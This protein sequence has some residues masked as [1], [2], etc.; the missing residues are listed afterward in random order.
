MSLSA[1]STNFDE[2]PHPFLTLTPGCG[3]RL[4]GNVLGALL[5]RSG[6][7]PCRQS[8]R[9][10]LFQ[11]APSAARMLFLRAWAPAWRKLINMFGSPGYTVGR[12]GFARF[13]AQS[14]LHG[15][16]ACITSTIPLLLACWPCRRGVP[17]LLMAP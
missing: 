11:P 13:A 7:L 12:M 2:L 5:S 17:L 10:P 15:F 9:F 16:V 8:I 14:S 4:I 6:V 1:N 3:L